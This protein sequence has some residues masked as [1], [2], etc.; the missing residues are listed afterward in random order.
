M[1]I[2]QIGKGIITTTTQAR[3]VE[4]TESYFCFDLVIVQQFNSDDF[5]VLI[6]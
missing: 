3:D 2:N 6:A 1:E 4:T 5:L